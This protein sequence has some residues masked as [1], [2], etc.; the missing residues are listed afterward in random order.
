ML[1]VL[2]CCMVVPPLSADARGAESHEPGPPPA[3]ADPAHP[4]DDPALLD[5]IAEARGKRIEGLPEPRVSVEVLT[6]FDAAIAQD[7]GAL[8]GTVIGSV[9]GAVVQASMPVGK[10]DRLAL[11]DGVQR[12][13]AP[14]RVNR[15][16]RQQAGFGPTTGQEVAS[17]S[18]T[19]W[20]DNGFTGVGAKVGIIDFFDLSFWDANEH[21]PV[22]TVANGHLFCRDSAFPPDE[23]PLDSYCL[24]N[25]SLNPGQG[26][27]HGVA[28]T[29][30]VKDMAPG[31][32]VFV[33]TVGSLSDMRDAIDWF[34]ANGVRIVTRSLGAAFDGPG[35]G[36]GPLD[37]L[38]DYAA[39]R[40][41]VW[42][43]SAGNDADG[44]YMVTT[45]P[46]NRGAGPIEFRPGD[47]FLRIDS[48]Q[49][50]V[51]LDGVRWS[52]D[53]YLPVNQRT[54]YSVEVYTGAPQAGHTGTPPSLVFV[55]TIDLNQR[56]GASPL[57][58]ADAGWNV[59]NGSVSYLRVV[60]KGGTPVGAA[61]DRIEIALAVGDI[62]SGYSQAAGSAAKPAVDSRNY[63]L[64]AVGALAQPS[65]P[66]IADYS[67]QG[68]TTDGRI[69]PDIAA[70]SCV[71]STIYAQ[72][73]YFSCFAGTSAA[74]PAAAGAAA[75]LFGAGM[76]LPGAPLAA[77][78]RHDVIDR[79][80]AGP[81]NAFGAGAIT[82]QGP[83]I[84][85]IDTAP[86]YY[87]PL[88]TPTR[89]LDTR[90]GPSATNPTGV[91]SLPRNGIVDL[92]LSG[93]WVPADASA[94]AVN[95]TST[96]AVAADFVQ[97]VPTMHGTL[98]A[99]SVLNV[100]APGVDRP[101]FA[102]VPL[103][104]G[105]ITL[106]VPAGGFVIVDLLGYFTPTSGPT[107]P[108]GRFIPISP[109]RWADSRGL[110]GNP[111]PSG[112][113][114]P[115][116]VA[117][118][119]TITIDRLASSTVPASGVKALVLN[120]TADP[121]SGGQAGFLRAQ[122][123]NPSGPLTSSTVN[124]V[125]GA[126]SANTVIVPVDSTERTAVFTSADA[127]VIVDVVGYFTDETAAQSGLGLFVPLT[128]G[129][130][131]DSRPN[132]VFGVDESRSIQLTG[133]SGG[134]P[135]VPAD[136]SGV[137][138]NL[139]VADATNA[140][141][142]SVFPAA[143]PPTSNVNFTVG[144]NVANAGLLKLGAGGAVTAKMGSAGGNVIIDINGYFTGTS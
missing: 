57:E 123:M 139:T 12:V 120:V 63:S 93:S 133:L 121:P 5:A 33:A 64:I 118:N 129:R 42:F 71:T 82:L 17:T 105:G 11:S 86:A 40:G 140:G 85:P 62:E 88:N 27:R 99:T 79:G 94:V 49:G 24:A 54:D 21:G 66:L 116:V 84:Q 20:H 7:V 46:T 18:A 127:N 4:I 108:S 14:R 34:S 81:D 96:G 135:I 124:F 15:L 132:N 77:L 48:S 95:I 102:V 51:L 28:V 45:V 50:F 76:A 75:L 32:E 90:G 58:G 3:T 69:K 107:V 117:A 113:G 112:F 9:P 6:T 83:P 53:W 137:S 39:D 23:Y 29:E 30:I 115:R 70:P 61:P 92:Q 125:P 78:M 8:G 119:E 122:P 36:T 101:N 142:L 26:D 144:L 74:S 103:G 44:G 104:S 67:S 128:P 65:S 52:N 43:N 72:A 89:V 68:P 114:G 38:V 138:A 60:R 131:F 80:P 87:T 111:L 25:G 31:A 97:A 1:A 126:A 100:P 35:D 16:P 41:L 59:P 143:E 2:A 134:K 13:R 109:E 19:T 141:Y 98:G 110:G 22:P 56:S 55:E 37:S 47:T 10:I 136:A 106:Y 91:G 130:A 73:P